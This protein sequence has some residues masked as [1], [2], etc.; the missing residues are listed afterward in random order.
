[1]LPLTGI[2]QTGSDECETVWYSSNGDTNFIGSGT[3]HFRHADDGQYMDNHFRPAANRLLDLLPELEWARLKTHLERVQMTKGFIVHEAGQ[4]LTH[5]YFPTTL[6]VSIRQTM[7]DGESVE[8]A[9]VGSDGL[10][11][12]EIFMGGGTAANAAVVQN[13]GEAY[14]LSAQVLME[15]FER[16]A[17]MRWLLLRHTL[18]LFTQISQTVVCNQYHSTEQRLCR[19]LLL[20][21]DRRP[22]NEPTVTSELLASALCVPQANMKKALTQLQRTGA[23]RSIDGDIEVLDRTWLEGHTCEC[24]RVVKQES[25][26]LLADPTTAYWNGQSFKGKGSMHEV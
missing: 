14:Q 1:M 26:R 4:H 7:T 25:D 10:V 19:W 15:E 2:V 16:E 22:L 18:A 3:Y 5:V 24:Y 12:S 6:T 11:G 20:A 17:V 9:I 23:I 21:I 8:I 13:S